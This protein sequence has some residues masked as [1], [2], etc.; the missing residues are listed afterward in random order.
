MGRGKG[1]G[2]WGVLRLLGDGGEG[3]RAREGGKRGGRGKG[4]NWPRG[5]GANRPGYGKAPEAA[6]AWEGG[7]EETL[8]IVVYRWILGVIA[9]SENFSLNW[10]LRQCLFV[11]PLL[12]TPLL[13]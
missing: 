12:K 1:G 4:G 7:M 13:N 8:L 9:L 6:A 3:G 2:N 5:E 10:P 11:C